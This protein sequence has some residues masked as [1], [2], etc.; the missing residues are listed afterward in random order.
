MNETL[1]TALY[2]FSSLLQADAAILGLGAIF[3][4]YKM[5]SLDSRL[6]LALTMVG[7]MQNT[8]GSQAF[9]LM[10]ASCDKARAPLLRSVVS[11]EKFSEFEVIVTV[12]ARLAQIRKKLI[13]PL[14]VVA[15]HCSACSVLLWHSHRMDF[16]QPWIW[17]VVDATLVSFGFGLFLDAR[18]AWLLA[19]KY[20]SLTLKAVKPKLHALVFPKGKEGL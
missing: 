8:K 13:L 7:G 18:L 17:W 2:L 10:Q 11:S 5:Q 19:V 9:L 14:V 3:I 12:P 16:S 6:N 15:L 4:I 20:D 1:T